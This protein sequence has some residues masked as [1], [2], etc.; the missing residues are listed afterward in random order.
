MQVEDSEK[1]R[2]ARF[3]AGEGRRLSDY[4]R[5]KLRRIDAMDAEDIVADVMLSVLQKTGITSYIESLPAYV[6][7][8]LRNRVVDYQRSRKSTISLDKCIDE[9]GEIALIDLLA[10]KSP[11]VD[12]QVEQRE[13]FRRLG[14]AIDSLEAS[15]RAVFIATEF[16]GKSFK[17]LASEW[18]EPIGTLLS[19]KSRAVKAL[20]E[21]LRD[22]T[23]DEGKAVK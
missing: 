7:R 22:Y 5:G 9:N 4:V 3:F 19:R 11:D 2:I 21:M 17:Q 23:S 10:D 16:D 20:R 18:N 8:S 1:S 6:Y 12:M 13:F 15:Q 14:Q